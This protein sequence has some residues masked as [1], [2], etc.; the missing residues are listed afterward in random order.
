VK[1]LSAV[2]HNPA[3]FSTAGFHTVIHIVNQMASVTLVHP[4]ETLTV[5]ALQA[6]TK[7]NL[8]QKNIMLTVA[9]YRVQSSVSLSIFRE[10][11]SA[12]K[13]NS[14]EITDTNSRELQLLC[15][16]FGFDELSVKLSKFCQPSKDF[17]IG[18]LSSALTRVQSAQLSESFLFVLN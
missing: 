8:F 10:F 13:G 7:C 3:N 15:A 11:I 18:Q 16:E 4:E 6:I 9:P 5:S 12:L 1:I 14:V 17:L 2:R